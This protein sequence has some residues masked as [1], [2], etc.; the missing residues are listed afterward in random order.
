M[1]LESSVSQLKQKD[2]FGS[3]ICFHRYVQ[4][5]GREC[6]DRSEGFMVPVAIDQTTGQ[7]VSQPPSV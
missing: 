4:G 7:E 1:S 3:L 6:A 5:S 2:I